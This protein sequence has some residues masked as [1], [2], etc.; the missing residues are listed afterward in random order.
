MSEPIDL[1]IGEDVLRAV[2]RTL[3]VLPTEYMREIVIEAF[4][5]LARLGVA[6]EDVERIAAA[7]RW[8][9]A[10]RPGV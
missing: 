3:N 1:R 6:S 4:A 2:A 10:G 5:E 8:D 9:R 7:L